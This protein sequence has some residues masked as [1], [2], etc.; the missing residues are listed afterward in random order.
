M[1]DWMI[2]RLLKDDAL[3]LRR[4]VIDGLVEHAA[5]METEQR[6]RKMVHRMIK[7]GE[8]KVDVSDGWRKESV[9][10]AVELA[11]EDEGGA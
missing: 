2:K 6:G 7:K 11:R 1:I 8:R 4:Q 10:G 9:D 5:E 3:E